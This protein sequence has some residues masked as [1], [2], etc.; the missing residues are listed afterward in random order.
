MR[1]LSL[2]DNVHMIYEEAAQKAVRYTPILF[3]PSEKH[4][5][6][7]DPI[8][9]AVLFKRDGHF[10]L[11]TAGH[12]I[13]NK[14]RLTN[15]G[16]LHKRDFHQIE[17]EMMVVP[18]EH[19]Q[20]DI[21]LVRLLPKTRDICLQNFAFLDDSH[22]L[23]NNGIPDHQAYLI[24]GHP[25]TKI[26]NDHKKKK[27]KTEAFA[28]ISQSTLEF[29]FEKY[30]FTQHQHLML[31]FDRRRSTITGSGMMSISPYP[32]GVSGGGV[33]FVP[34]YFVQYLKSVTPQIAGIVI[35]YFESRRV[36]VA[37]KFDVV[38]YLLQSIL[39]GKTPFN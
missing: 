2:E 39:T 34:D 37:T 38:D 9:S 35:E 29:N 33:W 10:L 14:G 30:H 3:A 4:P 18:G 25:A 32:Q 8:G 1:I 7:I 5:G 19:N 12:C 28:H 22:R 15:I 20:I 13:K 16:V 17:G 6:S 24:V 23:H 27:I 11:L 31:Q 26:S 36:I 21:G